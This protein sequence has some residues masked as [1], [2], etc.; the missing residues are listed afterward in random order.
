MPPEALPFSIR[1]H[2]FT[3]LSLR[4]IDPWNERFFMLLSDFI[5]QAPQ[6]YRHAPVVIDFAGC[7]V[8]QSLNMAEFCRRLRQLL[9][10]PIGVQNGTDEWNRLAVNAGLSLFAGGREAPL[11][12]GA[13][14]TVPDAAPEPAAA[15]SRLVS[16]P[17]R[18][19]QQ[20]Y[21]P[22]GDLTVVASVSNGAEVIADGSI[23]IYGALRGRALAGLSGNPAARIF[24]QK[25]EAELVS[26]AG[27]YI[28]SEQ[29]DRSAQGRPV[30][31]RL[32]GDRLLIEPLGPTQRL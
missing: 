13:T 7:E 1:G 8:E 11:R 28:V 10:V 31:I 6:F 26:I 9:L 23:H 22:G 17:V 3:L 27:V 32:D 30:Q 12:Q 2:G 14:R 16:E 24:C 4:V 25:L 18:S 15:G 20:V 29:I 21:A 19:G 5:A